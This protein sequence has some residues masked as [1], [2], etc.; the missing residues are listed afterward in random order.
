MV[1]ASRCIKLVSLFGAVVGGARVKKSSNPAARTVAGVP[2]LNYDLAYGGEG[3]VGIMGA[4]HANPV[5]DWIMVMNKETTDLEIQEMCK[6]GC[7]RMGHPSAGGLAYLEVLATEKDLAEM[8]EGNSNKA[9][10][11]EPN[12]AMFSIPDM[13][14]QNAQTSTSASWGLDKVGVPTRPNQGQ[15]V[16]VYL[17]DTGVRRTHDDFQGRV[18]PTLDLTIGDL[19]YCP[20]AEDPDSCAGD[21]QGH[22]THCAGTAA[23]QTFGVAS[24]ALI[25]SVKILSDSGQGEFAWSI[26][27]LDWMATNKDN[28]AVASMSLGGP[29]VLESVKDSMDVAVAAGVVV[30]VAGGNDNADACDF[31]P[32]YIPSAITVGSTTPS[33]VRSSFSNFGQC[34]DIWAPGDDIVSASQG[35]DS[36]SKSLSGTSM[37]CPHVSGAAALILKQNPSWGSAQVLSSMY[38]TA[39]VDA[40]FS[41]TVNDTNKLLWVGSGPAPGPV[42]LVCSG[43]STGPDADF[44]CRC[45]SGKRC[46][47]KGAYGCV[48]SGGQRGSSYYLASCTTCKCYR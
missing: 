13:E 17:V 22:G 9:K 21:I 19:V 37:A 20:E 38:V 25:R 39:S 27:A 29:A 36:G 40:I 35:S 46:Y 7:K 14:I 47:Q 6:G 30:V 43:N 1:V 10:Y 45:N 23:G 48:F 32:A 26:S 18:I 31:T 24:K 2:I 33:N 44:D 15:G 28:M 41:L 4:K 11:I 3:G 5:G 34:T 8:L 12:R 42:P 16:T